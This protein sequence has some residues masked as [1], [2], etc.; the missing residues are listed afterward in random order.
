MSTGTPV[1]LGLPGVVL[2]AHLL[3][4]CAAP[5]LTPAGSAPGSGRPVR[6]TLQEIRDRN[7]VKQSLD[8]S[9]GA[10]ALATLMTY[11][12]GDR[13]SESEILRALFAGLS[14]RDAAHKRVS[15]FSLLDLKRV[16]EA[17]GYQAA[18]F[19][20]T[21]EQ[22]LQVSAPIIVFVEPI[23]YK[24]FSVLRGIRRDVVF[25]ADPI[26]G[27]LQMNVARFV[28]EWSGIVF[29]LGRP[30]DESITDYPLAP[31]DLPDHRPGLWR[32]GPMLELG[33][34]ARDLAR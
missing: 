22:L 27:N 2:A 11:Y 29:V 4:G 1:R 24:H 12:F 18:G 34:F 5:A 16:A 33:S 19:R 14:E 32:V 6:H 13:V 23:G 31:P 20:L 10:A 7:V 25:L 21:F 30:G 28:G 17:R 9:C 15:G 3:A 8:Y 26:R